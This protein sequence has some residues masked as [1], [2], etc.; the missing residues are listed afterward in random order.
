MVD[1]KVHFTSFVRERYLNEKPALQIV[2]PKTYKYR[3]NR[4]MK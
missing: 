4:D 3:N 1:I 2:I